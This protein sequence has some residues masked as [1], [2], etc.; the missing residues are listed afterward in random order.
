MPGV[1]VD[2]L[3]FLSFVLRRV[4]TGESDLVVS[5]LTRE[6]GR[7]DAFARGARRSRRRFQG[8]FAP[9]IRYR[10]R[11]RPPGRSSLWSLEE[12]EIAD[13]RPR[14]V[15]SGPRMVAGQYATE[16][17]REFCPPEAPVPELFDW[18]DAFMA[19]LD[20]PE[21]PAWR[22]WYVFEM[23][24]FR[25]GGIIP[26]VEACVQCRRTD[27]GPGWGFHLARG[28][29]V[30]PG[31][32]QGGAHPAWNPE[33]TRTLRDEGASLPDGSAL[34]RLLERWIEYH[35]LRLQARR[36]C[37]DLFSRTTGW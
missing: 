21:T 6:K 13:A 27:V 17:V 7:I 14:L 18:M 9:C 20:A 1:H 25:A 26:Q 32:G 19:R 36:L 5:L 28:G 23:G 30:C 31:C 33:W 4:P 15:A 12:M 34:M 10:G 2:S 8:G 24:V 11:L 3:E 29:I 37:F 35:G 16:L 22:D